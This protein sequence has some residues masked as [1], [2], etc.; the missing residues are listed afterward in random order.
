MLYM[1]NNYSSFVSHNV[2]LNHHVIAIISTPIPTPDKASLYIVLKSVLS[3]FMCYS[4]N[5]TTVQT[6][7]LIA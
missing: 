5:K 1:F 3:M 4:K 7:K 6:N 2:S